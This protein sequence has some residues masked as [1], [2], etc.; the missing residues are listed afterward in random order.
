MLWFNWIFH[1]EHIYSRENSNASV[2]TV[3][4][5]RKVNNLKQK[6]TSTEIKL[7]LQ[8]PAFSFLLQKYLYIFLFT[9]ILLERIEADY[10]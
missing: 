6:L 8:R 4:V 5:I 2:K 3:I 1:R 7:L 10:L 9:S